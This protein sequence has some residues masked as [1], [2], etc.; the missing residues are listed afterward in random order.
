MALLKRQAGNTSY[1]EKT[2]FMLLCGHPNI[3][4]YH[5]SYID[6]NCYYLST[7]YCSGGTMLD[8][9]IKQGHFNEKQCSEFIKNVLF[10][11]IID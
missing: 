3:L 2:F 8:R 11:I 4:S 6:K 7:A 1:N 10:T 5:S 9:I